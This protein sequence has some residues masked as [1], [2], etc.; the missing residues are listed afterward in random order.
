MAIAPP[1]IKDTN[2]PNEGS[3]PKIVKSVTTVP[4]LTPQPAIETGTN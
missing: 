3:I 4:S 1:Q 2:N